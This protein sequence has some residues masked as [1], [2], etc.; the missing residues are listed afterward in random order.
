LETTGAVGAH[1]PLVEIGDVDGDGGVEF[2]QTEEALM[3]QSGQDPAL[4][5]ENRLLHLGLV[6]RLV[7]PGWNDCGAIVA[8]EVLISPVDGGLVAIGLGD[9][10]LEVVTDEDGWSAAEELQHRYVAGDPVAEPFARTGGGENVA[11]GA[12]SGD[13]QLHGARF[14]GSRVDDIDGGA[15]VIDEHLL[16]GGVALAHAGRDFTLPG[17]EGDAEPGVAVGVGL[18]GSV[19]L[20]KKGAGDV[21][22]AELGVHIGPVGHGTVRNFVFGPGRLNIVRLRLG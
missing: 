21:G 1:D 14:A 13:E 5:Q 22:A 11:G 7:R 15:G 19:L 18:A 9:A 16:A 3:T 8:G 6:L 17:V 20:P 12:H 2:G 4:S 10:R